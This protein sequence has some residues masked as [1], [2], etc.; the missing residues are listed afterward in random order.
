MKRLARFEALTGIAFAALLA[1][2]IVTSGTTPNSDAT[3]AAVISYFKANKNSQNTSLFFGALAV[4]VFTFFAAVL[5]NRLRRRLPGSAL[6][7]AGL[8]GAALIAVGGSIFS[9]LTFALTDVPDK[10]DPST[11]QA[12]NL[13]NNDLFF[14]FVL[15]V[16]VFLIANGLAIAHGGVLPRWLGWIA[17][18]IALTGPTP[19]GIVAF[20]GSGAWVLVASVLMLWRDLHAPAGTAPA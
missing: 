16:G 14:P 1:V 13:L 2:S 7:A 11:A 9:S 20:F 18:P 12:L 10:I 3:G 19:L 5:W 15:G 4:V 17:I 8:V 6:P